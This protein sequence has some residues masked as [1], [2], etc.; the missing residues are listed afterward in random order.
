MNNNSTELFF[1]SLEKYMQNTIDESI[2]GD[3]NIILKSFD[4]L[5]KYTPEVI[6]FAGMFNAIFIP[7]KELVKHENPNIGIENL[8]YLIIGGLA[9]YFSDK[10]IYSKI[11]DKLEPLNSDGILKKIV[12][13]IKNSFILTK[14]IYKNLGKI[15]GDALSITAFTALYVPISMAL[16][17]LIKNGALTLDNVSQVITGIAIALGSEIGKNFINRN[18]TTLKE[19]MEGMVKKPKNFG[20]ARQLNEKHN[21][22]GSSLIAEEIRESML[23]HIK[24]TSP[25]ITVEEKNDNELLEIYHNL[26]EINLPDPVPGSQATLGGRGAV[27]AKK[28]DVTPADVKKFT[29]K[30]M[31]FVITKESEIK[32]DS[33]PD[34]T[35]ETSTD[36]VDANRVVYIKKIDATP[37]KI[38]KITDDDTDVVITE[39]GKIDIA[40]KTLK[41]MIIKETSEAVVSKKELYQLI[42]SKLKK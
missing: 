12:N 13:F 21:K 3:K 37:D 6:K 31:D 16:M 8:V 11:K 25:E 4:D 35:P 17:D 20:K 38:K 32:E 36:V 15:T 1:N 14:D 27:Y 26:N 34:I 18:K 2:D 33:V 9:I 42:E 19:E 24:E 40:E 7:I 10:E 28:L 5:K 30:D 39:G 29:D 22:F 41:K 23:K